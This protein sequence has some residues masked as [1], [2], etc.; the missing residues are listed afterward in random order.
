M[1]YGRDAERAQI[2]ALLENA[3]SSRSGALV[4]RGDAGIGKSALLDDARDRAADLHVLSARGIESESEL[5]FAGLH[6][7]LRPGL[8]LLEH[9]PGPQLGALQGAFGLA[10]RGGDDRFLISAAALTLLSELAERRP[11]LCLVDDAQWIDTASTDALLFVARRLAAEGIVMLF[12]AREGEE[13]AFDAGGLPELVLEALDDEAATAVIDRRVD[14]RIAPSVREFLLEQAAG[15]ALALVELPAALTIDQLTG[16]EPLPEAIPLTRDVERLFL[17]RVQ[18]LPEPTQRLLTI[19]AVDN[20]GRLGAVMRAGEA[21]GIEADALTAAED[22]ALVTVR[23]STLHL[24]HPLVRSAVYQASSSSDRRAAHLALADGLTGELDSD[25]RAWHRAAAVVDKD[26]AAAD[27][28]EKAAERA[29]LRSGHA[30]AAAALERASELSEDDES[31]ARRLVAAANAAWQSGQ[32]ERAKLLLERASPIVTAPLVRAELEHVRGVIEW[33]CGALLDASATLMAGAADVADVDSR[34]ALD[35]LFDAGLAALNVG[36]YP[37]VAEAGQRAAAL[38]RGED[39]QDLHA[40]LLA[41]VGGLIEGNAAYGPAVVLETIARASRLEDPRLLNWAAMGALIA[42]DEDVEAVVLRRAVA[43]A[44]ASGAVETLTLVLETVAISGIFAGRY[45]V[46]SEAVEG[47][48]LAR[49]AGL[50]N[51]ASIHLASL[52]WFA[53]L[54]GREDECRAFA[55]EVGHA[56]RASGLANANSLAE[57]GV[58][59]LDLSTGR[60][61]STVTRLHELS[62][63]PPGIGHPFFILMSTPDLVE[64]CVRSGRDEQARTAFAP[65][66]SFAGA[67]APAWALG[68]ASRCRALLAVDGA[69]EREFTEALSRH[70]EANRPFDKARTELLFGEHLRRQRKRLESREHLRV[71]L[72]AFETLGAAPW[73]ERARKELRASGETARKR[74]PSTVSQL[75]PQEVQIARMVSEGLANKEVAAQLFLSPRTIDS[76]LRNVFAKLGITSRT[77]LARVLPGGD[78]PARAAAGTRAST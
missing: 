68:L 11:V 78:V 58:A 41:G 50:P 76:H 64:A 9:L 77:Q 13:R 26:E 28:L 7:L 65:F 31:T 2:W 30:A 53:A 29:R 60:P 6:Q 5:P 19:V 1:L 51:T 47:L 63:A 71:A 14:H 23:G 44:R 57:W 36:D 15:N 56:A 8:E 25:Q 16:T 39:G 17:A 33:R 69:A 3:R 45:G 72:E 38:P 18:R 48:T 42:G 35:M 75:T 49:E 34:K 73:A 59:L 12:S 62:A 46:A 54:E 70:T 67:G 21:L 61:D 22:A 27:E 37:R 43:L 40:D 55:A 74:D 66:E 10:E 20:S 32:P 24:R 4:I 52:A